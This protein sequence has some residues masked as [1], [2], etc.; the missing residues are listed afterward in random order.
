LAQLDPYIIE[1]ISK[2]IVRPIIEAMIK[3]ELEEE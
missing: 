1:K 3:R 2:E